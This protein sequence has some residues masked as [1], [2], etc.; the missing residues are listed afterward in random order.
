MTIEA[1][2]IDEIGRSTEPYLAVSQIIQRLRTDIESRTGHEIRH[3]LTDI[4]LAAKSRWRAGAEQAAADAGGEDAAVEIAFCHLF[5]TLAADN[6]ADFI[7]HVA[8]PDGRQ[9]RL[10]RLAGAGDTAQRHA[11]F[12]RPAIVIVPAQFSFGD[13]VNELFLAD[14]VG[15]RAQVEGERIP[16]R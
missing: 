15:E 11:D 1:K 7:W 8:R 2:L 12:G 9:R 6:R 13:F 5:K 3:L 14:V 10:L 4:I 16:C